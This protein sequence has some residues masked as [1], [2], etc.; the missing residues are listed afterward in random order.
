MDEY[1]RLVTLIGGLRQCRQTLDGFLARADLPPGKR[2]EVEQRLAALAVLE[3]VISGGRLP[4]PRFRAA[5]PPVPGRTS[6]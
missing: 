5:G 1:D 6:G 3:R 4:V 2:P